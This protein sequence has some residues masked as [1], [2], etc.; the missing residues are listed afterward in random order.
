[1]K[2][3]FSRFEASK[4]ILNK[5]ALVCQ[6]KAQVYIYHNYMLRGRHLVNFL[7]RPLPLLGP[8]MRIPYLNLVR[9]L[10]SVKLG[11]G[12]PV[13]RNYLTHDQPRVAQNFNKDLFTFMSG[14]KTFKS[15]CPGGGRR[16]G[17]ERSATGL[18]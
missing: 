14:S 1:M 4:R 16:G 6:L 10:T 2:V 18:A 8:S 7:S 17:G 12:V 3:A 9:S 11:T 13:L 15:S 5:S